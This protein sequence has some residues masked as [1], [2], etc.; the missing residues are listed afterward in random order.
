MKSFRSHAQSVFRLGA[1]TVLLLGAGVTAAHAQ[2][3]NAQ[4]DFN[5]L[6]AGQ[7]TNTAYQIGTVYSG[8]PSSLNP[9]SDPVAPSGQDSWQYF[10][11]LTMTNNGSAPT[12]TGY[13]QVPWGVENV[14]TVNGSLAAVGTPQTVP[15]GGINTG[16]GTVNGATYNNVYTQNTSNLYTSG[17]SSNDGAFRAV[18]S[19]GWTTSLI[20]N[21]QF[22]G[23]GAAAFGPGQ[24]PTYT[25]GAQG[26]NVAFTFGGNGSNFA[27]RPQTFGT[28][29]QTAITGFKT[30][31]GSTPNVTYGTGDQFE[32]NLLFN[33]AAATGTLSVM[34]LSKGE[35]AFQTVLS[36]VAMGTATSGSTFENPANWNGIYVR[37][38]GGSTADNADNLVWNSTQ[39][40]LTAASGPEPA[41]LALL[42][43]F[44][45][46]IVALKRRRSKA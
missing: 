39:S 23:Q 37:L 13:L 42:L 20:A 46:G 21:M 10:Y 25:T 41:S 29:V 38:D 30:A 5:S 27:I 35:T 14:A 4:Y 43:P 1:A 33:A 16:S 26:I 44:A 2:V 15:V 9:T 7:L 28:T 40:T 19:M 45:G 34:D 32:Y 11:I 8:T 36:N 31:S 3:Y 17:Q 12:G 18:S 6:S 22:T 24:I